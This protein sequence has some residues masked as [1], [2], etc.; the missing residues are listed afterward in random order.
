MRAFDQDCF[1]EMQSKL[2]I[3]LMGV[4]S[5]ETLS[6]KE[7]KDRATALL[8]EAKSVIVLGKEIFKE[9]LALLEPSIRSCPA[10][11]LEVPGEREAYS[12]NKFAC[13]VYRQAGFTCAICMKVCDEALG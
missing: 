4:A 10:R 5:M 8:A 2:G 13:Q 11:A 12:M 9:G 6:T 3:E 7:L 1:R